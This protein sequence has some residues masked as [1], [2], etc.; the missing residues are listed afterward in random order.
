MVT[1]DRRSVQYLI[2]TIAVR[3]LDLHFAGKVADFPTMHGYRQFCPVAQAAEVF[4]ER[5]TPLVLRELFCGSHRFNDLL[6]GVPRM[7]RTLLAHR[8]KTMEADGLVERSGDGYYLTAAGKD[9]IPVIELLGTWGQRW[10]TANLEPEDLDPA[11][12][13]WDIHRRVPADA[14]PD[15]RVVAMVRFREVPKERFWLVLQPLGVDVCYKDPG[16]P[17]DL[18]VTTTLKALTAVWL[19]H[20]R[21]EDVIA[22]GE[23]EFDGPRHLRLAFPRWLGLSAFAP[24]GKAMQGATA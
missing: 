10:A 11:L 6:R 24:L 13:M 15:R 23:I 21:I 19:G 1:S 4:A 18:Q 14:L 8:L 3:I 22:K 9:L 5:W 12:L 17:V 20:R 7:S 16:H 2:W